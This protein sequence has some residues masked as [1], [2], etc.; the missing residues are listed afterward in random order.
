MRS[1]DESSK[2]VGLPGAHSTS[3]QAERPWSE[4]LNEKMKGWLAAGM[5]CP[6]V[7]VAE[8]KLRAE[9]VAAQ[10]WPAMPTREG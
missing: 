8:E 3:L 4:V 1:H 7:M 2:P 10:R 9:F 5:T 6:Q